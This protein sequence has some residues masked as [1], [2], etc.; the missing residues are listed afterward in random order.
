MK[1]IVVIGAGTMGPGIAQVFAMGG[2][3]VTVVDLKDEI[4]QTASDK[5]RNNLNAFIK[6]EILT[7]DEATRTFERIEYSTDTAAAVKTA[8]LVLEAVPENIELKRSVF[9]L[10]DENAPKEA[11]I[12]SNT[13]GI[14]IKELAKSTKREEKVIGIHFYNP[15]QL[16]RLVE[17]I[18]TDKTSMDTV[19]RSRSLLVR[20]GKIPVTVA[21]IPGFLHN[22]LIYALLR[23]A[24]SLVEQGH[25]TIE[26]VD[27]VVREAFGPRFSVL[28]LFKLV[29][30]VGIDI[31]NSVSSY[32]NKHLSN[33]TETSSWIKSKVAKNELGIKTNVGFYTWTDQ[34]KKRVMD[35][36]NA[37]MLQ[38]AKKSKI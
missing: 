25:T 38:L 36:L 10:V 5:I 20:C 26:D 6:N 37:V 29:D 14:P 17:I 24:V 7:T 11:I 22:R 15:A 1:E 8:D 3:S 21:D 2:C 35:E 31:Y 23:E 30:M 12:A 19:E 34:E 9:G 13:S 27:A 18:K 33:A 28:G 4:L 16:N 32:L